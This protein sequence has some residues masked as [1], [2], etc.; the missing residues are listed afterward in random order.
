MKRTDDPIDMES[1]A[2]DRL[3]KNVFM[4][5]LWAIFSLIFSLMGM[6]NDGYRWLKV[7]GKCLELAGVW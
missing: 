4:Y 3:F 7:V 5:L 2:E 1:T 6:I